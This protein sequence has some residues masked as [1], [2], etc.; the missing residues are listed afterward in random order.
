MLEPIIMMTA[1]QACKT[2]S[3]SH[4]LAQQICQQKQYRDAQQDESSLT[5]INIYIKIINQVKDASENA[6]IEEVREGLAPGSPADC[7]FQAMHLSARML[8]PHLRSSPPSL[9]QSTSSCGGSMSLISGMKCDLL[10]QRGPGEW[11]Q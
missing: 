5:Q 2:P 8:V 7:Y 6:R 10:L 4:K 1:L 3:L 9:F 11:F